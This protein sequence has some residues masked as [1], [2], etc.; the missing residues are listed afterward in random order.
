[1]KMISDST[2][3]SASASTLEHQTYLALQGLAL[4]LKDET[5]QLLKNEGLTLTQLNVLRILRGSGEDALTCGDIAGRL[6]N[7]DPDVTRLLDRMEKQGL[8]E[9][10]RSAHD[11]RVLLT[12]LSPQGRETVAR[13]DAP[14]MDLHR[15]QFQHLPPERLRLLLDLLGEATRTEVT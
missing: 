6:L 5:E 2:R 14:L 11:R 9:R 7:K 13:L 15:R 3:S 12:R 10:A 1:M 8:I 4:G